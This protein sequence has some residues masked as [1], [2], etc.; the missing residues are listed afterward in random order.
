MKRNNREARQQICNYITA[1]YNKIEV[2]PG[3]E[4]IY[5]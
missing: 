4:F 2:Q 1:K 5:G 3:K